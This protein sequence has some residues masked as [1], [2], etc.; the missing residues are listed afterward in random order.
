MDTMAVPETTRKVV[1][2]APRELADRLRAFR[3]GREIPSESAA[4]RILVEKGLD[5][6]ER[7]AEPADE[8][9]KGRRR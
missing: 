6:F 2:F 3:F 4:V 9:P 7:E 8:K 1:F 5:S